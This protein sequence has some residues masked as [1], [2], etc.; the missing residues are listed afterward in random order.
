MSEEEEKTL[1]ILQK[2]TLEKRK[3]LRYNELALRGI[4]EPE[5]SRAVEAEFVDY[6]TPTDVLPWPGPVTGVDLAGNIN[7][8]IVPDT[9]QPPVI[10]PNTQNTPPFPTDNTSP[11]GIGTTEQPYP[12]YPSPSP[13]VNPNATDRPIG[14]AASLVSDVYSITNFPAEPSDNYTATGSKINSEPSM[15]GEHGFN[16]EKAIPEWRYPIEDSQ[17][18]FGVNIPSIIIEPSGQFNETRNTKKSEKKSILDK[19]APWLL[20]LG[21]SF[22]VHKFVDDYLSSVYA[23]PTTKDKSMVPTTRKTPVKAKNYLP[24][25]LQNNTKVIQASKS[26]DQYLKDAPKTPEE[27]NKYF[28]HNLPKIMAKFTLSSRHKEKDVC[29]D[30]AGKV[31]DLLDLERPIL[32]TEGK[33][34]VNLT[35]PHCQC[36]WKIVKDATPDA[37]TRKQKTSFDDIAQHIERAAKNHTLHTVKPDGELSSRTRGTSPIKESIGKIR[38]EFQWMSDEYLTKM[39][40]VAQRQNAKLYL[41]RAA[42][43]TITDHRSEGEQYRRKLSSKELNA[44]ARTAIGK[45]MD[46]NHNPDWKTGGYI[47]DSEYDQERK[48]IQMLVIEP[49]PEINAA[50]SNGDITAVSI[51]GGNPRSQNIE[52]CY[53]GCDG[54]ECELCNAPSGVI[55]G[56][57]D[58]VAM[59]WVITADRGIMWKGQHIPNATPGIKNTVLE[60]L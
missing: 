24:K 1:L 23:P 56:E 14:S 4:P 43:A 47:P 25:R 26:I 57:L 50:I 48:E 2:N 10:Q 52:P 7:M 32:P 45:N 8:D 19:L 22:P 29:D 59:T 42:T 30:Y 41:I 53:D 15:E 39:K 55:L 17:V 13:S 60:I 33:G 49:D 12:S 40:E 18:D 16:V 21:V 27:R 51:N 6:P 44:T 58:G 20:F 36:Y 31:F 3:E 38:H 35:H 54:P 5:L 11:Y 28:T 34:Y 9:G 37:L 46:L